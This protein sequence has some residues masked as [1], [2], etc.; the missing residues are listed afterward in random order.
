MWGA[1]FS[2]SV[3]ITYVRM[4]RI[5]VSE[6]HA[7]GH[8]ITGDEVINAVEAALADRFGATLQ[9]ARWTAAEL[10]DADRL[11]RERF[12]PFMVG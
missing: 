8:P 2:E 1:P 6:Y 12:Q 7:A 3:P 9:P 11:E 10:R 4:S 5:S